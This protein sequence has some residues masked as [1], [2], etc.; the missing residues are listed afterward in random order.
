MND[1]VQPAIVQTVAI[2]IAAAAPDDDNAFSLRAT[3]ETM[4]ARRNPAI[5]RAVIEE[6]NKGFN[7]SRRRC[8]QYLWLFPA[9]AGLTDMTANA[10]DS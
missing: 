9:D 7:R 4:H 10:F 6:R 5:M 8:L 2:A 1:H 3:I